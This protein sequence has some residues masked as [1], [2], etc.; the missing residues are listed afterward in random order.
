MI[1]QKENR[2]VRMNVWLLKLLSRDMKIETKNKDQ[3]RNNHK[4]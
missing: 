2:Q 1:N 3:T 4:K